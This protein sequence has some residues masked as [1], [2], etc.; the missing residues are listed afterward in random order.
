MAVPLREA[1]VLY[2]SRG[3]LPAR[4]HGVRQLPGEHRA[5]KPVDDRDQ[6]EELPA[7]LRQLKLIC[8]ALTRRRGT[9][10]PDRRRHG[11]LQQPKRPSGG[12]GL[13]PAKAAR[14]RARDK[15]IRP[16][17]SKE[18]VTECAAQEIGDP[19]HRQMMRPIVD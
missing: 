16:V 17:R 12:C 2:W 15:V 7:R 10:T 8:K 19:A 3:R 9:M 13:N 18:Q 6:V 11:V 14:L 1:E 5:R 4:V